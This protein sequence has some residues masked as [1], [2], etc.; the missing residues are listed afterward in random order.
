MKKLSRYISSVIFA[1]ISLVL[2]VLLGFDAIA[3]IIDEMDNLQQHYDFVAALWFVLYSIPANVFDLLPFAA[4]VGCLA[5][6]GALANNSELVVIRSAG[7]STNRVVWMVMRPA[8]MIMVAGMLISEYV[9]PYSESIA[10]SER[11]I[12]LRQSENVVSREGLWHREGN[13]F[14]HFSVV[15]PNGVLYGVTIYSFDE[16]RRLLNTLYA[17][18]AIYQRDHWLLED[19]L[20]SRPK[21][22]QIESETVSS[23]QWWTDVSPKLLNLL[24][25]DPVNLSISGLWQYSNYLEGQGL[26]NGPYRLAFW[27]KVLQPL[28]TVTLVLIAISFVFGPLRE[29]TM[30]YRIFIGVLVGIIFRTA[31]DMLAPASMVY[32]FQPIY[33]SLIPIIICLIIGVLLLRKAR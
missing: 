6:L 16:K 9:A 5:G 11:A 13:Q 8:I 2:I 30:G 3:A 33:A 21:D 7:V 1:S 12:A 17:E 20:E 24:V 25:L 4:L 29:V 31:Q 26:N 28:S 14:M 22:D 10:Q 23:K 18:R 19:V 15:Q 27:K 32:G